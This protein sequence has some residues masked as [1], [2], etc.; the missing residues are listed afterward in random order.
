MNLTAAQR[1]YLQAVR[2]GGHPPPPIGTGTRDG[3]TAVRQRL[4]AAGLIR[5]ERRVFI[6][7]DG[8]RVPVELPVLTDTGRAALDPQPAP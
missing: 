3:N 2:D 8:M 6:G 5:M 7:D 1:R 4:V